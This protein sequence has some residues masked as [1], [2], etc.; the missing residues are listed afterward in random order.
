LITIVIPVYNELST[1]EELLGRVRNAPLPANCERELVVIDDFSTDGTRDHLPTLA[2]RYDFRLFLHDRNRGKGAAL[3]TGFAQA[4]G[5]ILIIQDADLEYDPNE[6]Q[7]L[8]KPILDGRADVVYGSRFLGG[9]H[10]V[11]HFWHF[12]GNL[13]ITMFSNMCTNLNLSDV[14]TCYKIFRRQV[15]EGV[16]LLDER[17]GFEIEFTSL[18]A[19]RRW[20]IYEHP[21]SYS[22]RDYD[23]GKKIGW[24]DGVRAMVAILKYNFL[25][26]RRWRDE[27]DAGARTAR[28]RSWS[29]R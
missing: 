14:E 28:S 7:N 10:R 19:R 17:F 22:G 16:D 26:P 9:P 15:I 2:E 18:I 23:E 24:R 4:R 6:Y 21:I 12:V 13:T 11:L 25:P 27:V 29:P 20:R 1:F 8:L 3:K 5:D